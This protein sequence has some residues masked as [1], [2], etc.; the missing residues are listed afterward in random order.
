MWRDLV[1][2]RSMWRNVS[3]RRRRIAEKTPPCRGGVATMFRWAVSGIKAMGVHR[4]RMA[5]MSVAGHPDCIANSGGRCHAGR[6]Q[7]GWRRRHKAAKRKDKP[8]FLRF[9][10]VSVPYYADILVRF[11]L[12]SSLVPYCCFGLFNVGGCV[13]AP[14]TSRFRR[15]CAGRIVHRLCSL[16][17]AVCGQAFLP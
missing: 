5:S 11:I 3:R 7:R 1:R 13:L 12:L 15:F 6:R 16:D 14:S 8:W 4:T 10:H 17:G 2:R 9:A